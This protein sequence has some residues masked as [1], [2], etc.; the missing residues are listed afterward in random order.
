[1]NNLFEYLKWR[2]DLSFKADPLNEIDNLILSKLSYLP[3]DKAISP[4]LDDRE[5]L[6]TVGKRLLDQLE[7][8]ALKKEL[9][10]LFEEDKQLLEVLVDSPRYQDL[11]VFGFVNH[12]D[13]QVEKQ[14][15]AMTIEIDVGLYYVSYRG[16][17]SS[18]IGWKE[19]FNMAVQR[20]IPAQLDA[21]RYLNRLMDQLEGEFYLGGH[22]KGGNLAVYAGV[23]VESH[24]SHRVLKIFSNDGPGF[25]S[26]VIATEK[27]QKN[28]HKIR[29][30]IPEG[31]IVG[32]LLYHDEPVTVVKSSVNLL[33]QH[34]P[35][36]WLVEG[37]QF[38]YA[39][40]ISERANFINTTMKQWV[41][42]LD[43]EHQKQ[44]INDIFEIFTATNVTNYQQLTESWFKSAR[45]AIG[46]YHQ[47]DKEQKKLILD[48]IGILFEIGRKNFRFIPKKLT[49]HDASESE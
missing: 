37:K 7:D 30:Y 24:H 38:L 22:S 15:C 49:N 43:H 33:F 2:K 19:D 20:T 27:F 10:I 34:D 14:F 39:P 3:F 26:S 9:V 5:T 28:K 36:T 23:F 47:Y 4:H 17:D 6:K 44:V 45:L 1:M 31:S 25:H 11:N 16:T 29:S 21:V 41:E 46:K 18:F 8:D 12:I 40:A 48:T 32:L 42:N 35:F 13:P